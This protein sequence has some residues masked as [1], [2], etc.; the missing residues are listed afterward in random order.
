[1]GT[2]SAQHSTALRSCAQAG[3]PA[4]FCPL[5]TSSACLCCHLFFVPLLCQAVTTVR[6]RFSHTE[7]DG[8]SDDAHLRCHGNR[9]SFF[10]SFFWC[11]NATCCCLWVKVGC[12]V[13]QQVSIL[14]PC[15][16]FI[17]VRCVLGPP[18][19]IDRGGYLKASAGCLLL[20]Y[21]RNR[22]QG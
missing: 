2:R 14:D 16:M 11:I 8:P 6:E 15:G 17:L 1:M 3:R 5:F 19:E 10:F 21:A 18:C 9:T 20:V 7:D 4:T 13:A 12:L 22:H